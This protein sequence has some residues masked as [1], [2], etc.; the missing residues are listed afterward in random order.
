MEKDI[1]K[2]EKLDNQ[3]LTICHSPQ[4]FIKPIEIINTEVECLRIL[5]YK[6]NITTHLTILKHI[7]ITGII[8]ANEIEEKEIIKIY[9]KCFEILGFCVE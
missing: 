5:K 1:L 4:K 3:Y 9:D 2:H 8:F 6:I 7:F